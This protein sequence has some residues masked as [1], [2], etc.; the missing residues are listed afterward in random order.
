MVFPKSRHYGW[1]QSRRATLYTGL[2]LIT[3]ADLEQSELDVVNLAFI[4]DVDALDCCGGRTKVKGPF[5][6]VTPS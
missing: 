5:A 3:P 4:S 1:K 2:T 6:G